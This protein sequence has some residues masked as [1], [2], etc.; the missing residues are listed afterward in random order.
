MGD[1][2]SEQQDPSKRIQEDEEKS[3]SEIF[4]ELFPHY[5]AIGMTWEQYWEQDCSL[6]RDYRK[7]FKI[8]LENERNHWMRIHDNAAWL[9]G[10][11]L[12]NALN[13]TYLLVNGFVPKGTR[14][15]DYPEKPL[16]ELEEERQ[17]KEDKQK[18]EEAQMK[19]AMAMMHAQVVQ[20][21]KNFLQ[22][23]KEQEKKQKK[24]GEKQQS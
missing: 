18:R 19:Y 6:V 22:R 17:K 13:S 9:N 8:R 1:G 11:Y 23:Q 5:L 4:H 16:M 2:V 12:R 14:A 3:F 15:I 10:L 7:A 24:Q 20:F 21:N